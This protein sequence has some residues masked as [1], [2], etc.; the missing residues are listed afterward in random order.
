MTVE[1]IATLTAGLREAHDCLRLSRW[2]LIE[3]ATWGER[4]Q[5]TLAAIDVVLSKWE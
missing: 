2:L 5:E 4:A 3:L 1:E